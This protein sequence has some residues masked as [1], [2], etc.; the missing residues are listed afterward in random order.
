MTTSSISPRRRRSPT[1]GRGTTDAK[2]VPTDF[3]SADSGSVEYVW[4]NRVTNK[5]EN[6]LT[7]FRKVGDNVVGVG[8]TFSSIFFLGLILFLITLTLNVIADRFVRR[9]RQKY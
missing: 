4:L 5:V 3:S 1:T 2:N 7:Q 9:V 6:K 8:N